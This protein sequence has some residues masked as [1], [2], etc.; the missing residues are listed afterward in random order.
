MQVLK[1]INNNSYYYN[2]CL[3]FTKNKDDAYDL[4]MDVALKL[5]EKNIDIRDLKNYFYIT[6][7]REHI[8]KDKECSLIEELVI[9]NEG[10]FYDFVDCALALSEEKAPSKRQFVTNNIFKL[11]LKHKSLRKVEEVSG[12]NYR[13]VK[14][15]IDKFIDYAYDNCS[16]YRTV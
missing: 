5:H 15:H 6:A 8:S 2:C 11:Y 10:Y 9:A 3:K 7:L 13:T 4:M 1:E 12:I 14:H 16:M